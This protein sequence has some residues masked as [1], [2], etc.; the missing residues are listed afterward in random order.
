MENEVRFLYLDDIIPNR[1]QPRENFDEQALKEL[2]V[3]IKEHG[4][5][6]PIVVRQIGNK[7]EIIA[8]E[9]RYKAST[10]AGL[11]KIPAIIKNLDDKESSK[12]A[13]IENLQRKDL[14]PIEEARTYQ[15]ILE[16]DA[17]TQEEL[18]RTM[19]KSQS[20]VSNKLRLL[21]LTDEVQDALLHEQ[22]S[23]RHARSLLNV[24]DKVKQ[25]ELLNKV[26]SSRM[27]VR[28]LDQ[29]IKQINGEISSDDT[30][31]GIVINSNNNMNIAQPSPIIEPVIENNFNDIPTLDLNNSEVSMEQPQEIPSQ[32]K[33]LFDM[34]NLL[35]TNNHP[36]EIPFDTSQ[37]NSVNEE[38]I[39]GSGLLAGMTV[40][41]SLIQ[42]IN[43]VQNQ[44]SNPNNLM[45]NLYQNFNTGSVDNSSN[46][47][48]NAVNSLNLSS[49]INNDSNSKD[50]ESVINNVKNAINTV[51][52]NDNK[53][54][55]EEFDFDDFY[56]IVIRID[57]K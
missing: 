45:N 23:E 33:P 7:Y 31:G 35:N 29:T 49:G 54:E 44:E 16:L 14:T 52:N 5:I 27:T 18:A 13:L 2:A 30:N 36:N 15:K 40:D 8:G 37:N 50:A 39:G 34:S 10:M 21:A 51:K 42:P 25:I 19:G 48:D 57:K 26:I 38:V 56:Q 9:R 41:K 46:V 4:V 17:L 32:T 28:E 12:V 47:V 20:A 24:T 55:M 11:T 6:Q 3:S 43:N 53:I 1:F 22:I